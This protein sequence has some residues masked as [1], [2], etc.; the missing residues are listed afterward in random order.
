[1]AWPLAKYETWRVHVKRCNYEEI[2]S[3]GEHS[4]TRRDVD[5]AINLLKINHSI[6]TIQERQNPPLFENIIFNHH[7]LK[8]YLHTTTLTILR[9]LIIMIRSFS[10]RVGICRRVLILYM[11]LMQCIDTPRDASNAYTESFFYKDKIYI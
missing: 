5:W 8:F 2:Q 1:M 4:R 11:V 6:A 3:A 10:C 7:H 9:T